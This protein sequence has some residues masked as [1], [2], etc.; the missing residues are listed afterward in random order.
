[1][2]DAH[3]TKKIDSVFRQYDIEC[4]GC[5]HVHAGLIQA[6]SGQPVPKR[7]NDDCPRCGKET[8]HDR[9]ISC[10]AEYMGEKDQSPI[11]KG[12]NMDTAGEERLPELPTLPT[13]SHSDQYR[14]LFKTPEYKEA[15]RKRTVVSSNNK[16]KKRRLAAKMR[17]ENVNFK[18]DRCKGDPN[19]AA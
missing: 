19:F 9:L 13:M 11:V 18:R 2:T 10:P 3:H 4:L 1:M 16:Q 5:G 17:G 7:V 6:M 15:K 12:G 8:R 14:D